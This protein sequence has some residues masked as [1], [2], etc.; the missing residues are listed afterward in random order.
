V[1]EVL[2]GRSL[3]QQGPHMGHSVC[4][5]RG[6][7]A[8][9]ATPSR[10]RPGGPANAMRFSREAAYDC[11]VSAQRTTWLRRLQAPVRL[12]LAYP[13]APRSV[14][15]LPRLALEAEVGR[16]LYDRLDPEFP[17]P[18][19]ARKEVEAKPFDSKNRWTHAASRTHRQGA[20]TVTEEREMSGATK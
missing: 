6:T 11:F 8:F 4:R 5:R 1:N 20:R 7:R 15:E 13:S 10:S 12:R 17:S 16:R 2:M 9:P 18:F 19:L 14:S 3:G